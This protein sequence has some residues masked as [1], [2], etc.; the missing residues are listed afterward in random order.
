MRM[1]LRII[2]ERPELARPE[3]TFKFWSRGVVVT[4]CKKYKL[5][6]YA[7]TAARRL[8]HNLCID[9]ARTTYYEPSN[10]YEQPLL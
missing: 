4:N 9:I 2:S 1:H 5:V 6:K 7:I 10:D 8:A 3:I